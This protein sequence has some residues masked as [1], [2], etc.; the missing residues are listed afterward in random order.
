MGLKR[1]RKPNN[2]TVDRTL[3]I[4]YTSSQTRGHS[5]RLVRNLAYMMLSE[6]QRVLEDHHR[7]RR[8]TWDGQQAADSE[9]YIP[10]VPSAKER[11][12]DAQQRRWDAHRGQAWNAIGEVVRMAEG[13]DGVLLG[14]IVLE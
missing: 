9:K 5:H 13:R 11:R 14:R 2:R 3:G 8:R 12:K 1:G 4:L 7:R 10:S 6:R